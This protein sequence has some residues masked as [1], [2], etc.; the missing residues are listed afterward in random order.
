MLTRYLFSFVSLV[1]FYNL[2]SADFSDKVYHHIFNA[3]TLHLFEY[4]ISLLGDIHYGL[5]DNTEIGSNI[6]AWIL[7]TPNFSIKKKIYKER[8]HQLASFFSFFSSSTLLMNFFEL[9]STKGAILT[10]GVVDTIQWNPYLN[11]NIGVYDLIFFFELDNSSDYS[12]FHYIFPSIGA[13]LLSFSNTSFNI[14]LYYPTISLNY[15]N[16]NLIKLNNNIIDWSSYAVFF[17]ATYN[18]GKANFEMGCPKGT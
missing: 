17:R 11:V 4:K 16:N 2:K 6:L 14:N 7:K 9:D 12:E 5:T 8:Q 15:L 1:F 10:L 18:Y 13:D 3:N